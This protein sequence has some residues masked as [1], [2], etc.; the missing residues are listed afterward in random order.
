MSDEVPGI[1]NKFRLPRDNNNQNLLNAARAAATDALPLKAQF[2]AHDLGLGSGLQ[3]CNSSP[4]RTFSIQEQ[5]IIAQN[6]KCRP[7]V[8]VGVRLAILRFSIISR[9]FILVAAGL[10]P[11]SLKVHLSFTPGFSPVIR[12]RGD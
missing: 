9:L 3:F 4:T 2:I 8:S 6:Q 7:Q 10:C 12:R 5:L 1:E 11:K